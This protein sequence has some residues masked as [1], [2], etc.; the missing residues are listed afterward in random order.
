MRKVLKSMRKV[1]CPL[2]L[3]LQGS[4]LPAVVYSPVMFTSSNASLY[5]EWPFDEHREKWCHHLLC[6]KTVFLLPLQSKRV[7]EAVFLLPGYQP[8]LPNQQQGFQGLMGMQQPPQSQNLMNNQ[9]GNQVQG[10]MVQYP[11]MSS[12]QVLGCFCWRVFNWMG[13]VQCTTSWIPSSVQ[14]V[15]G[16]LLIK[17]LLTQIAF[18]ASCSHIFS[19]PDFHSAWGILQMNCSVATMSEGLKEFCF[20]LWRKGIS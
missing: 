14:C 20:F 16:G 13:G 4:Q 7:F 9:Q 15:A 12:Y 17:R 8:V 3:A 5:L 6:L 2:V 18:L 19:T 1:W 10:M 11:A